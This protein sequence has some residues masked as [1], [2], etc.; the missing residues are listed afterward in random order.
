[1]QGYLKIMRLISVEAGVNH[2]YGSGEIFN[3]LH[4]MEATQKKSKECIWVLHT[5]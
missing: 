5:F 4:K 1:M 3:L 2:F